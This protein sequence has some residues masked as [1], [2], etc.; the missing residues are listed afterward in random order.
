MSLLGTATG[1]AGVISAAGNAGGVI[2]SA[3]GGGKKKKNYWTPAR[4]KADYEKTNLNVANLALQKA[5]ERVQ[6]AQTAHD[7]QLAQYWFGQS[8]ENRDKRMVENHRKALGAL[9]EPTIQ[10]VRAYANPIWD[11]AQREVTRMIEARGN[12]LGIVA[13]EDRGGGGTV[14]ET[15]SGAGASA[16]VSYFGGTPMLLGASG[17]QGS[18][19]SPL[20]IAGGLFVGYLVVRSLT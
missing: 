1:I 18:G 11:A 9:A 19:V 2:E 17:S 7:L 10:R 14:S 5:E 15:V 20:L 12:E 8:R 13:A 3:F 4:V 6:Q 16:P